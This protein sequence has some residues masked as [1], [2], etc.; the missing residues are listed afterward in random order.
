M[1]SIRLPALVMSNLI[2][3]YRR[4][5]SPLM[6]PRCRFEPS[7]SEYAAQ[8][9][10]THGVLKGSALT[11]ARLAKCHPFH[12]GGIDPVPEIYPKRYKDK[13]AQESG[14]HE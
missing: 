1:R 7:C 6:G 11:V 14:S 9:L 5:I 8:A 2:N 3:V 4:L 10:T 12:R 13:L